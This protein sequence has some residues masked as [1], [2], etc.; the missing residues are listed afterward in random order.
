VPLYIFQINEGRRDNQLHRNFLR[1]KMQNRHR[2]A[3]TLQTVKSRPTTTLLV[4]LRIYCASARRR[5]SAS[6][7]VAPPQ[8]NARAHAF[9]NVSRRVSL[10]A[11]MQPAQAGTDSGA[12]TAGVACTSTFRTGPSPSGSRWATTR[13]AVCGRCSRT[14]DSK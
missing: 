8:P 2:S 1:M 11:A 14:S 12:S 13:K 4:K 5:A 9:G 3:E 7:N 6:T 10:S